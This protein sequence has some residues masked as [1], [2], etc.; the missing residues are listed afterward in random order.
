MRVLPGRLPPGM[1]ISGKPR[2]AGPHP[3]TET[4]AHQAASQ[5]PVR[6]ENPV[7][8]SDQQSCHP[9]RLTVMITGHVP[10]VRL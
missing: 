5:G 10:A 1:A 3:S 8:G 2:L 4:A 7:Q 9:S 6:A